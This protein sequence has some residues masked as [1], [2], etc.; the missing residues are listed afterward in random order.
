[1][2]IVHSLANGNNNQK[3]INQNNTEIAKRLFFQLIY[4]QFFETH[5]E[6]FKSHYV[7]QI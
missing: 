5:R 3:L 2:C 6:N 7:L 4:M 1:M